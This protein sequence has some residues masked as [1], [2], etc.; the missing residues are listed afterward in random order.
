[1]TATL[2]WRPTPT[3]ITILAAIGTLSASL[4][5]VA[6]STTALSTSLLLGTGYLDLATFNLDI[7]KR[8]QGIIGICFIR[9]LNEAE[10]PG[11]ASKTVRN[12]RHTDYLPAILKYVYNVIFCGVIR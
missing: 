2:A 12:Q 4:C 7:S 9:K 6:I 1:M 5:F 3:V 10:A 8:V 11:S